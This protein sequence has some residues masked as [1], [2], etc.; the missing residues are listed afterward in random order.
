MER[1]DVEAM[2]SEILAEI[3]FKDGGIV[4]LHDAKKTSVAV[5]QKLLEHMRD[6]RWNPRHPERPG[7]EIVDLPQYLRET[8]AEPQPF[9][10]REEL[11][12]ARAARGRR[13][14]SES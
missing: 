4:L 11:E 7:Y 8:A 12:K 6:R 13:E 3:D 1:D 9:E 10:S 5:L 14:P 2:T